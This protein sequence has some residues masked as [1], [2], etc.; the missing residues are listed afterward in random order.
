MAENTGNSWIQ[1]VA[2]AITNALKAAVDETVK[3]N[4][5]FAYAS[6]LSASIVRKTSGETCG[7]CRDVAG[8][9]KYGS[10][11]SDVYR[12][13]DNCDC[14]VE[15]VVGKDRQNV[16]TKQWTRAEEAD[17]IE[18]RKHTGIIELA[19]DLVSH[20]G[21]LASY[22]PGSLKTALENAGYIVK[23]L[24]RGALKGVTFEN[25]GGYKV[26]FGGDGLIQY[27]SESGSHHGGA[28]YKI[29]SGKQGT[30][31]YDL[32]GEEKKE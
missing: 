10:E 25:G 13:H 7:W 24:G 32:N 22:T 11:P 8:T 6:G 19:E 30:R 23:P 5:A 28:Y 29:A 27:H 1:T 12:R 18:E 31:H 9:Y 21:K 17:K 16:H 3:E 4:A 15:Y 2:A 26:N 20:P 14:T